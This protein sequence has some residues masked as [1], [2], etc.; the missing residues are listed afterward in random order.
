MNAAIAD[1]HAQLSTTPYA[2]RPEIEVSAPDDQRG[3]EGDEGHLALPRD[4]RG[5]IIESDRLAGR[6]ETGGKA[7]R[8]RREGLLFGLVR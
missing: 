7:F 5:G 1:R 6:S 3:D 2:D 8:Q 4:S